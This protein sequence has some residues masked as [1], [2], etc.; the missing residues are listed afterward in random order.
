MTKRRFPRRD[1]VLAALADQKRALHARELATSLD[2]QEG[3]YLRFLAVLHDMAFDGA[4]R[5]L[6]GQRY[7]A[8]ASGPSQR[9]DGRINVHP[10]G[11]AFVSQPGTREDVFVPPDAVGGAMHGD[12]VRVQVTGR[13][14]RGLEGR[15][16]EVLERARRRVQGVLNNRRGHAW[17]EPDDSRVRG[18]IVLEG[19]VQGTDGYAA[20]VQITRYPEFSD[21]APVAQLIEV[22]GPPGTV[23]VET[24]KILLREEIEEAFSAEV[25]E[26]ASRCD[27]AIV[28]G[29][30]QGRDDLRE[31]PFV[32]IDP[33]DA[34]D[35]DDAIFVR[36]RGEGYEVWVA[37]ADVAHFV[38]AATALDSQARTRAF[39]LYLPD[40][41]IPML[42][43]RLASDVC[44]LK[45][46]QNRLCVAV[47]LRVS[48]QG[49]TDLEHVCEGVMRSHAKLTYPGV[50]ASMKW[51]S[52]H[53]SA[54]L[55][56]TS[57]NVLVAADRAARL[58]RKRR[59]RRGALDLQVPEPEITLD[60]ATGR[61]VHVAR[62]AEDP[63]VKRAYQLVEEMMLAANEAVAQFMLDHRLDAVFRVH[64]PP[65]EARLGRLAEIC[66]ALRIPFDAQEATDPKKLGA[67]LVRISDHPLASILGTLTLRSLTQ[68]AYDTV[69]A[70]HYGLASTA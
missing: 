28:P 65:D 60:P 13:T 34:R 17:L 19:R 10:R 43:Q 11:F 52:A 42:P 9:R 29:D 27:A 51:T 38:A 67:F 69:N 15:V 1:E 49:D 22:I 47:Q 50:A 55:D 53:E 63:G 35:H 64:A 2:V 62:R 54:P 7:Q 23:E 25:E 33:V 18:P 30:Y 41:A 8:S 12:I 16:E 5:A 59:L 68:A 46:Q 37:I 24:R 39:S 36:E 56:E 57:R 58:L 6:P 21:E 31:L 26:E 32:T 48:P 61:P 20:V 40:R 70:G 66:E 45:P 4:L 14:G 3:E 44:S